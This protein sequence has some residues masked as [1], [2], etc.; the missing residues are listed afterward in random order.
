VCGG[1]REREMCV[2]VCKVIFLFLFFIF[3]I[4]K[5]GPRFCVDGGHGRNRRAVQRGLLSPRCRRRASERSLTL[6]GVVRST[7]NATRRTPAR[8]YR[9]RTQPREITGNGDC[10]IARVV[11]LRPLYAPLPF[12]YV[13]ACVRACVF[14]YLLISPPCFF[15]RLGRRSRDETV[16]SGG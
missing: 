3:F 15:V 8:T 12:M 4:R 14:I 7:F 11:C 2:S 16:W 6:S 13:C 10:K 1:Q 9:E 5:I